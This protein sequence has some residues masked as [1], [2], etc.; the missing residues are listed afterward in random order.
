MSNLPNNQSDLNIDK[1]R[2]S[3]N[4]ISAKAPKSI[5]KKENSKNKVHQEKKVRFKK[6]KKYKTKGKSKLEKLRVLYANVNGINDKVNSLQS[7]AQLHDA[8]II[9]ITETKQLPPKLEGYGTWISKERKNRGGGGVA[10]TAK[11]DIYSKISRVVEM[12]DDDMDV[13]WMEIRKNQ[14]EKSIHW[15]LLWQ[16]GK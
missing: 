13:V 11:N 1:E 5:L 8:S 6:V 10:I 2:V 16:T 15:S 14:K 7:A 3:G 12:E 4:E 9:T